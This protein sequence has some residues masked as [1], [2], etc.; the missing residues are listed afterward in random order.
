LLQVIKAANDNVYGL[1]A[2]MLSKGQSTI[3]SL[4]R[5]IRAG[6]VWVNTYNC[7]TQVRGLTA[8]ATA[9]GC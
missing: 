4:V 6:T 7:M 8:A 3:D 9:A 2:G 1:A 5:R